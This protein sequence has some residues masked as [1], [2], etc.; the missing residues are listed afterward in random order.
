[1]KKTL[2]GSGGVGCKVSTG[3]SISVWLELDS[4]DLSTWHVQVYGETDG[5]GLVGEFDFVRLNINEPAA[6][7]VCAAWLPGAQGYTVNVR[8]VNPAVRS[9]PASV[10][11]GVCEG[12][13]LAQAGVFRIQNP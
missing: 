11:V 5:G 2:A 3:A 6:R 7:Y 8:Q 4:K 1:V 10:T 13:P 12:A 9:K